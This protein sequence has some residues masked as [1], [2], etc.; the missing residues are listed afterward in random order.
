MFLNSRTSKNCRP[1]SASLPKSEALPADYP[2]LQ[3]DCLH[4]HVRSCRRLP[5]RCDIRSTTFLLSEMSRQG[6]LGE[7]PPPEPLLRCCRQDLSEEP[8]WWRCRGTWN[9]S[10]GRLDQRDTCDKKPVR[11]RHHIF[12]HDM[13][14]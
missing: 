2:L 8:G 11:L 12:L 6:G 7:P 9:N 14:S 13:S 1:D 10:Q 5:A 3:P 4:P